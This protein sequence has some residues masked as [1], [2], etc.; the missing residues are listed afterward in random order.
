MQR[1]RFSNKNTPQT[2]CAERRDYKSK[3]FL[4]L[5]KDL[6]VYTVAPRYAGWPR[7]TTNLVRDSK[8]SREIRDSKLVF[9]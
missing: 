5:L 3:L 4:Y 8:Y 6:S 7:F 9:Q 2:I 1:R